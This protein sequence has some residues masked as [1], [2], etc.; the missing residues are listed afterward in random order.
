MSVQ[1]NDQRNKMEKGKESRQTLTD[2]GVFQAEFPAGRLASVST[3]HGIS[4]GPCAS[5]L[6]SR[7]QR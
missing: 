7:H 1:I 5:P 6:H 3:Q 2:S 4:S